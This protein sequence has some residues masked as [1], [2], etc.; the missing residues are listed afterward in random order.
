MNH[1]PSTNPPR[2][3]AQR[4]AAEIVR[5]QIRTLLELTDRLISLGEEEDSLKDLLNLLETLGRTSMRLLYL[6]KAERELSLSQSKGQALI[7]ASARLLAAERQQA[8]LEEGGQKEASAPEPP[9]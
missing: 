2:P 4:S 1:I 8:G 5:S 3:A 7:D 6:L 9:A